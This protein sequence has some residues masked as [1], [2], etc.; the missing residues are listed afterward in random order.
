MV[1]HPLLDLP[2]ELMVMICH[3]LPFKD[4][5]TLARVHRKRITGIATEALFRRDAT[6]RNSSAILWA[7]NASG[8]SVAYAHMAMAILQDSVRYGGDVNAIHCRNDAV[9]TAIHVAVAH[10][11]K[12][13]VD[14][15]IY[16]RAKINTSS[17]RLWKFL[18]VGR[19]NKSLDRAKQ[20]RKF[21]KQTKIQ[22][23]CWFPLLPA[24]FRQKPQIAAL[25]VRQ[26]HTGYLALDR[27]DIYVP[28]LLQ[29]T[30]T[31]TAYT[32]NHFL[33][34]QN[35]F[36]DHPE[37]AKSLF[38]RF[39]GEAALVEPGSGMPPLMK[40]IEVGNEIAVDVFFS[41]PQDLNVVSPLGWSMLCYAVDG[42]AS[43]LM[44][45]QRN[46]S[47][48]VVK[49]LLEKGAGVNV[50]GPSSP[51]QLAVTSALQDEI[52]TDPNHTKRMRQIIGH[53]LDYGADVHAPME[54]G[55]NL[56]QYIFLEMQENNERHL[57]RDLFLQFL[58]YGL[59]VD[60]L[61]PDGNSLFAKALNSSAIGKTLM[62]D[63]VD[64]GVRPA[65]HECDQILQLWLDKSKTLPKKIEQE[66]PL[67][68]PNFSQA[69][70]DR[71]FSHIVLNNESRLFDALSRCRETSRPSNLLGTA[72]RH[73]FP[74]RAGLYKLSFDP[75]WHNKS[76]QGYGHIV[77]EELGNKVY[78]EREAIEE[79][80]C[81]IAKGLRL[82]LRDN[83]DK[84]VLQR[85]TMLQETS[86][87]DDPWGKLQ[88][89]LMHSRLAE[90][91]DEI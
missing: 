76:G 79:M 75:N 41:F 66:L 71:A 62:A 29:R 42:A 50:G 43:R 64:R 35:P 86:E 20:L 78:P 48:T 67:L 83:E 39:G 18:N 73:R 8:A 59:R 5:R 80:R 23:Y 36:P 77:V 33:A 9:C 10:G 88:R 27:K 13:F 30:R 31:N 40:A 16:Y 91:T 32:V 81:L 72:L 38:E 6:T 51:L 85:L 89:F 49:R 53:L 61:F 28:P 21:A 52:V 58:D 90:I 56:G 34:E 74:Q 15:L 22:D 68:A 82:D 44:P 45:K 57:L 60:D 3:Y 12:G 11:Q 65:P 47:A 46:W 87:D 37:A 1:R 14:E 26:G 17:V 84:T 4:L 7:A 69:A 25:L 54:G 70:V 19:Y 55:L 2:D 63:I 24:L